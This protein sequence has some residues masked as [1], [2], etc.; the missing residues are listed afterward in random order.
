MREVGDQSD[1][2][3]AVFEGFENADLAEIFWKLGKSHVYD[4]SK[5]WDFTVSFS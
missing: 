4:W 1:E 2:L 5:V 3:F